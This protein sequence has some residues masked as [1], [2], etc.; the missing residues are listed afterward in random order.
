MSSKDCNN[1]SGKLYDLRDFRAIRRIDRDSYYTIR[2]IKNTKTGEKFA[3][4]EYK[5][6]DNPKYLPSNEWNVYM[7]LKHPTIV[8]YIGHS[9]I[10]FDGERKSTTI[11]EYIPRSLEKILLRRRETELTNTNK[12]IILLGI[13]ISLKYI[14]SQ[15]VIYRN[16]RPKSILLDDQFYPRIWC[17]ELSYTTDKELTETEMNDRFG[18]FPYMAPEYFSEGSSY[19]YKID[20][21]SFAII[22][23]QVMTCEVVDYASSDW[24]CRITDIIDGVRP[25]INL[26]QSK[27]MRDLIER[28]WSSD[29]STRPNFI[30]IVEE[31]KSEELQRE[32][33]ANQEEISAYLDYLSTH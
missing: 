27:K 12:Y 3:A 2:L 15:G 31:M 24:I 23:Y 13:A 14:H 11:T 6:D 5:T 21:Y 25:D 10:N 1:D 22:M 9:I 29:P 16:I 19:S 33:G 18:T 4:K 32:F 8:S 26:V 7:K 20:V 28:C 30:E 17:F